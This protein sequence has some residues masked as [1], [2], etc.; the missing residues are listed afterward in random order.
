MDNELQERKVKE[1]K[2]KERK[3]KKRKGKQCPSSAPGHPHPLPVTRNGSERKIKNGGLGF[4]G[5]EIGM[6]VP[7]GEVINMRG[8]LVGLVNENGS[9]INR[10]GEELGTVDGYGKY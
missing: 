9:V 6:A 7:K 5:T 4:Y 1:S 2:E 10:Y 8:D 3:A